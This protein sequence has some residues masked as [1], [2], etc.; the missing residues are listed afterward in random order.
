[1]LFSGNYPQKEIL[2]E[3]PLELQAFFLFI[4]NKNS[5][6]LYFTFCYFV[7]FWAKTKKSNLYP[8]ALPNSNFY[9]LRSLF[10]TF[11]LYFTMF[12]LIY[13]NFCETRWDISK[14]M[15]K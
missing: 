15:Y 8:Q 6:V 4:I 14:Y 12:P 5:E 9:L 13:L 11:H 2:R 7:F 1:M 3:I 10:S